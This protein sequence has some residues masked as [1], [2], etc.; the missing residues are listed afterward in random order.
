MAA[1]SK[2]VLFSVSDDG[3]GIPKDRLPELF[4]R[5]VQID[6]GA[7][8]DGYKGTGLGLAICKEI[9]ERQQGRIWAESDAGQGAR[10][11][12]TLPQACSAAV[13]ETG[14]RSA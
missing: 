8:G 6:R 9:V 13:R 10:F 1:G 3:R 12:F 14:R 7:N 11:Y 2:A 4:N 5:F